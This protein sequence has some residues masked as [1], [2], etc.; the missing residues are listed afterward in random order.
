MRKPKW[1]IV[2]LAA[3]LLTS[4]YVSSTKAQVNTT[5]LTTQTPPEGSIIVPDDYATIQDAVDNASAGGTVFV[6]N[7][8][9]SEPIEIHKPLTL[10]GEDSQNTILDMPQ[11]KYEPYAA[12][13]IAANNV[14][15]SGFT[16]KN[17]NIGI[18]L[19][20]DFPG[21]EGLRYPLGC[22]ITGNNFIN[23]SGGVASFYGSYLTLSG[24]NFTENDNGI[25]QHSSS[26]NTISSNNITNN[27]SAGIYVVE[28]TNVTIKGNNITGNGL[29]NGGEVGGIWVYGG[30]PF[31]ICENNIT[32]NYVGIQFQ[33]CNNSTVNQNNIQRNRIG[34]EFLNVEESGEYHLGSGNTVYS[35]NFIANSQQVLINKEYWLLWNYSALIINGTD[36][37]SWDNGTTGNYWSNYN[38]IDNNGDGIGDTPYVIDENNTDHYPFMSAVTISTPNLEQISPLTIA[39]II[40]MATII[41]VVVVYAYRVHRKIQ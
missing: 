24:N 10:L 5:A 41:L 3:I 25:Y 38:G 7:G 35:N 20:S 8:V 40:G 11:I 37:V 29:N 15:V 18:A 4:A 13:V 12:I 39:T 32:D 1:F 33:W 36:T 9:Y 30:G 14:T 2:F 21:P 23:N 16:I 22:K 27:R 31:N 28:C 6:K 19:E 26:N 17:S 34:I